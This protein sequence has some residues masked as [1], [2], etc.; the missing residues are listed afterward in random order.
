MND[1]LSEIVCIV[2]RSGSMDAIREDAIGG[3]N[4]FLSD[5]KQQ[6]GE[7]ML[8]LVLFNH[9]YKLLHDHVDINKV[10]KL[11]KRSY[12]PQGMTALLDAVGRTIDAIG[13]RLSDTP[14]KERP[15]KVIVAILTDGLE[16]ASRDYSR[17]KVAALIQQ[18][19][20]VYQWEF[21]F[22][23]A[24]QDAIASAQSISIHARDSVS[25]QSTGEGVRHAYASMS[26][27]VTRRRSS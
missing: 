6:P 2:D 1:N 25:F 10:P 27:E 13:Q 20:D 11:D 26:R 23:A 15:S 8:S 22:L 18:Q 12:K 7:A 24:N 5:Q 3:F 19:R 16:N 14:E 17:G 9:E 21:I 4:T